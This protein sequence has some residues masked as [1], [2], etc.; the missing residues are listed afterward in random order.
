MTTPIDI[1]K[2]YPAISAPY[3]KKISLRPVIFTVFL[4]LVLFSAVIIEKPVQE[5]V[6]SWD[7]RSLDAQ[8]ARYQGLADLYAA[9][10]NAPVALRS[11]EAQ[12]ARYQGLAD[13]HT[14]FISRSLEAQTAR[15]QGL[16]NL[17]VF[18]SRM[19]NL[20]SHKAQSA[21][22]QAMAEYYQ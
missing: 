12:S 15:Y 2:L 11:F 16:A 13:L 7:Y 10:M 5:N 3:P 14:S 17:Y 20:R 19:A 9:A 1:Q 22:Y 8:T 6:F 21:R 4:I 18:K